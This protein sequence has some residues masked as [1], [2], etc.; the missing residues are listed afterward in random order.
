MIDLFEHKVKCVFENLVYFKAIP[1]TEKALLDVRKHFLYHDNRLGHLQRG[2]MEPYIIYQNHADFF[3]AHGL[4]AYQMP[5]TRIQYQYVPYIISY[6][7]VDNFY[8]EIAHFMLAGKRRDMVDY[9]LGD[10]P[11]TKVGTDRLLDDKDANFEEQRAS[12]LGILLT[13]LDGFTTLEPLVEQDW[14]SDESEFTTFEDVFSID[15]VYES[16]VRDGFI[17]D[18]KPVYDA[19]TKSYALE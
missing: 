2:L 1:D 9:G 13:D 8:H 5:R 17:V 16:L 10:G 4:S 14:I 6:D 7:T 18:G 3:W 19:T 15:G 11:D 12:A